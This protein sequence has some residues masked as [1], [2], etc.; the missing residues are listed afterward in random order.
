MTTPGHE[1]ILLVD[2]DETVRRTGAEALTAAGFEVVTVADGRAAIEA[3]ERHDV[4]AIV[5]DVD[6]PDRDG[7]AVCEWLRVTGRAA[8]PVLILTRRD[9]AGAIHAASETGATDFILKPIQW[10]VL[11]H[12]LRQALC[13]HSLRI[14]LAASQKRIQALLDAI[15]DQ[16]FVVATDGTVTERINGVFAGPRG[17]PARERRLELDDIFPADAARTIRDYLRTGL[18]A[19]RRAVLEYRAPRGGTMFEARLFPQSASTAMVIVRDVTE[20]HRSE[21][22]VRQLAYF[23]SVTGLPNR[24]SF[25][26]E[27]RRAM[28]QAQGTN[29]ALAVLYVDLDRFK[30]INDTFGHTVGDALLKAVATR[31]AACVRPSDFLAFAVEGAGNGPAGVRV[32]RLGGDEFVV[33]L[34]DLDVPQEAGI[35]AK[36]IRQALSGPFTFEERQ[37]VVTPSIGI[38]LYPRDG[39]DVETLLAKADIAMYQAKD[40]RNTVRFY[41]SAMGAKAAERLRMEEELR[42]AIEEERLTLHYQPKHRLATD[43]VVGA[44][45]LLRWQHAERGFIPPAEFIPLAEETGLIVPLGEWVVDEACAQLRRWQQAGL[46]PLRL[47]INIAAEQVARSDVTSMTLKAIWKHGV[48]PQSLEIEITEAL[49]MQDLKAA[50]EMMSAFKDAGVSL[51]IDDFGTGY[52][53][54]SYLRQFPVETLKI[55]RSFVQN[56]HVSKDDAVICEAIIAMGK[57]LGLTVVAEGVE[58]E[59]QRAFLTAAGCDQAQG[60]LFSRPLPATELELYLK[61]SSPDRERA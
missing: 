7:Y 19:G 55:D 44:E 53:S 33:L 34:T 47:A 11:L 58:L 31:L 2:D 26:R 4:A 24:Q 25:V 8:V 14:E 38:A 51:A 60:F 21:Q 28:R 5:L 35:V 56:V 52:T 23:D 59:E 12:R 42:R 37:F 48:R 1:P 22:H 27:L 20:R 61:T 9:D 41:A 3:F 36:R 45:A 50:R 15:P 46:P 39:S 40:V 49:L 18:G 57:K 13:A 29:K 30:R 32:A 16:I 17:R 43:V 6:M 10:T 54:L